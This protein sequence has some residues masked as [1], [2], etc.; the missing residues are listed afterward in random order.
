MNEY[1][2]GEQ[3][4]VDLEEIW[5]YIAADNPA[6]AGRFVAQLIGQI[7]TLAAS[8]NIGRVRPEFTGDLRCFPCGNYLIFYCL[9]NNVIEVIRILSSFRD[10][11]N[12]FA[13]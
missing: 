2:I 7:E 6:E 11:P 3:A 9:R 12:L 1:R 5:D 13:D 8:P 10:V 4:H